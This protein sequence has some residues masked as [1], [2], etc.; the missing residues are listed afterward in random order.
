MLIISSLLLTWRDDA[1]ALALPVGHLAE[2]VDH[3][4][5]GLARCLGTDNS[6]HGNDLADKGL[7]GLECLQGDVALVPVRVGFEE[8]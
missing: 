4:V 2:V 3:D 8:V 6:L 7:L 5:A 1:V